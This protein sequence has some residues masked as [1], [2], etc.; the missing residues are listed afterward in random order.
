MY[1][2]YRLHSNLSTT[3]SLRLVEEDLALE[4]FVGLGRHS[5][6]W[7]VLI[8]YIVGEIIATWDYVTILSNKQI[9]PK[10][11]RQSILFPPEHYKLSKV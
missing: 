5:G 9:D 7:K 3:E 10:H 6:P 4:D 8:T 11:R 1:I 2:Y